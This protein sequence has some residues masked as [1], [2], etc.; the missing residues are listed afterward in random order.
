MRNLSVRQGGLW[1]PTQ[2]IF[3]KQGGT[4]VTVQKA[5]IKQGG[6]WKQVYYRGFDFN[7]N[8]WGTEYG[9]NL[10]SRA[11]TAGWD[12][13]APLFATITIQSTGYLVGPD[14]STA[15]FDT[16]ANYPAWTTITLI[17]YQTI[18]GRGGNGGQGRGGGY[19]IGG[20]GGNGGPA[21]WARTPMTLYNYG[22]IGGGGGGG[23]GE[24]PL[25]DWRGSG[26]GGG[27]G[28]GYGSG[29]AAG[30]NGGYGDGRWGWGNP[31]ANSTSWAGGA[32]GAGT[33]GNGP[34]GNGG[35]IGSAG[36]DKG[37]PYSNG[38]DRRSYGG[39][40]GNAV[41]W[42]GYINWAVWGDVRGPVG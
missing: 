26:G 18:M 35:N 33:N 11:V 17:N 19:S 31:G 2:R 8:M 41:V 20:N 38:M 13:V 4:W 9:F 27:G 16:D 12:Q 36:E 1:V 29:G 23:A 7:Y 40:P 5:Y 3:V 25:Y 24:V 22:V 28:G 42:N 21:V 14:T 15:A 32:G 39:Q 34:G 30:D 6:T 37:S 10:R